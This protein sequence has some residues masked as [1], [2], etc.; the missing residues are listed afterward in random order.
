M[1]EQACTDPGVVTAEDL[2]A[3][4]DGDAPR[5]VVEHLH[6]CAHCRTIARDYRDAER[7]LRRRL[8]RNACPS[9][10]TLGEYEL[11]LLTPTERQQIA[12]HVLTC[13]RCTDE[14]RSLREF[15]A[16]ALV[17]VP[18]SGLTER[19]RRIVANLVPTAGSPA[20]A[21]LRGTTEGAALLYQAADVTLAL[22]WR[23]SSHSGRLVLIGLAMREATTD[24][25]VDW[26]VSGRSLRLRSAAGATLVERTDELGNFQFDNLS[27]DAYQ[28]EIEFDG[29]VI[30]VEDLQLIR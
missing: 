9:P 17:P 29:E 19:V 26:D 28:L 23:A 3:Y 15:M 13:D 24:A 10:Q 30:V 14:L 2:L 6:G 27:P 25:A 8:Y 11:N 22:E 20:L 7:G 1:N 5:P 16:G 21:G 4:L 18:P 12:A